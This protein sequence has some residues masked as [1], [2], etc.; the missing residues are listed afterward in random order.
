MGITIKDIA[1]EANVST[2]TVSNVINNTGR[3]SSDTAQK[4]KSIIKKHDYS[5]NVSARNL[6]NKNSN[7][8]GLVVPYL[9]KGELEDNPFFWELF[10]GVENGAK[11]KNLDVILTGMDSEQGFEVFNKQYLDGLIVIGLNQKNGL[12]EQLK[13]LNVPIVLMDSFIEDEDVYQLNNEDEKGGYIATRYLTNLGHKNIAIVTGPL[14]QN[15]VDKK[16]LYGYKKALKES[17]ID[18]NK[19]YVYEI[20]VSLAEGYKASQKLF[21]KMNEITAVFI[22]SDIGAMGLIKGCNELGI[23]IPDD[24]SVVGYDDLYYSDYLIPSLTTVNQNI[25][26]KGKTAVHMLFDQINNKSSNKKVTLPVELKIRNSTR[27]I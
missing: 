18:F 21:A 1:N 13:N 19:E 15:G 5:P 8:I 27:N 6:K 10:N 22:L 17:N 9:Q 4:I 25:Y 12:Y 24:L 2:A 23:K 16:R 14:D 20:G 3:V 7:L 26:L 11:D